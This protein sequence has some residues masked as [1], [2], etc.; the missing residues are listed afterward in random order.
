M[1][2]N[3]F[4]DSE[5]L[6]LGLI[7]EMPRHGYELEGIIE[8][9]GMREWTRIGFSSIYYVL[10]KL[11]KGGL[12]KAEKPSSPKARKRYAITQ[13]GKEILIDQTLVALKTIQPTYPSL[14]LGMIHLAVLSRDQVL[15]V[16]RTRKEGLARE[17]ERMEEIH[18]EQQPLPDYVDAIFE[19]SIGQLNAE[20]DW[21]NRTLEYMKTKA[22]IA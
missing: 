4:T 13:K 12:I 1:K 10:G 9:R 22:W 6:I 15:D 17:I 5:L 21:L 7:A 8:E 3:E 14:L 20:A 18:F 19:F 11:E 2:T 16:L